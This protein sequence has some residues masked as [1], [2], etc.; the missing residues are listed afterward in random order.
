MSLLLWA[1]T[2]VLWLRSYWVADNIEF[3]ATDTVTTCVSSKGQVGIGLLTLSRPSHGWRIKRVKIDINQPTTVHPK[4]FWKKQGFAFVYGPTWKY[5]GGAWWLVSPVFLGLPIIWMVGHPRRRSQLEP[6]CPAPSN[7]IHLRPDQKPSLEYERPKTHSQRHW[8]S[9]LSIM[10]GIS[11][12]TTTI[13][14]AV[15][16]LMPAA[17][18]STEPII[19]QLAL[20]DQFVL[21]LPPL[22]IAGVALGIFARIKNRT[23]AAT[24]GIVLSVIALIASAV[25][26]SI[27]FIPMN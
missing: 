1:A 18:F 11:V 20:E 24:L 23:P 16:L 14:L 12:T 2:A 15:I 9:V 3:V 6:P 22:A 8:T 17:G 13:C 7:A 27:V 10:I 5:V 21:I 19:L 25:I 4:T 26:S